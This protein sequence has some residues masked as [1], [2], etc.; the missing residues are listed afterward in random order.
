MSDLYSMAILLGLSKEYEEGLAPLQEAE[1][2][3]QGVVKEYQKYLGSVPLINSKDPDA[4]F[5]N[6]Y[7]VAID[8]MLALEEAL[9][10]ISKFTKG[11]LKYE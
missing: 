2:K 3:I 1:L 5:Y 9:E 6:K 10:L 8:R 7:K 4:D 11:V